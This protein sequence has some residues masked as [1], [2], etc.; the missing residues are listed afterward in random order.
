MAKINKAD[1]GNNPTERETGVEASGGSQTK[2]T[3]PSPPTSPDSQECVHDYVHHHTQTYKDCPGQ[4]F[5]YKRCTLCSD[6][7]MTVENTKNQ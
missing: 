4:K 2:A 7:R 5:V 1:I 6:L 3:R